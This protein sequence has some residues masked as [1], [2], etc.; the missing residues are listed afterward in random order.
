M[1]GGWGGKEGSVG[2]NK[3]GEGWGKNGI[4]RKESLES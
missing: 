1:E 4:G 3:C 2:G